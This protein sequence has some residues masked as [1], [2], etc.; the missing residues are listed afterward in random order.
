MKFPNMTTIRQKFPREGLVDVRK[1]VRRVIA[2]ASIAE[3]IGPGQRVGITVGSR[4]ISNIVPIL[5]EVVE[6]VRRAGAIPVLLAAMGSHGGGTEEGQRA[7][8][9]GLGITGESVGAPV[10][11]SADSVPVGKLQDGMT[12]LVSKVAL[13]CDAIIVVNRVKPHTSFH[14]PTE[15]GLHKMLAI[16]LGGPEGAAALH[17][18]G[19]LELPRLI[20]AAAR[21]IMKRL[22]IILGL[23][24][25][26]D[27]YDD[28]KQ[29]VAVPPH[30]FLETEKKL[31]EEAKKTLPTLPVD[32]LD[33]LIIESMGKIYSGTGM[34]TNVIGRLRITGLPE[35]DKPYIKRIVILDLAS[36]SEGNGNGMGLADFTTRKFLNK[37]NFKTTYKNVF[38]STF[39][40]RAMVPVTLE[41]DKQTIAAAL[42]SLG[43]I[44]TTAARVAR[45]HNTLHLEELQVSEALLP[46]LEGNP[47]IEVISSAEEMAFDSEENLLPMTWDKQ[48]TDI[49]SAKK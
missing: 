26:E 22:P 10:M 33:M 38:T 44:D 24:I 27:A 37:V 47:G 35:P 32:A 5:Q 30:G 2:D 46:E 41:T 29:I 1:T 8:L 7:V 9:S 11:T 31:L 25:L 20:P 42:R 43:D 39:V 16:G 28:T 3:K 4:G 14:G 12:V 21:V 18:K 6:A 34:D 36:G 13:T 23:A 48:E 45:I 17:S 49:K 40:Q 15:S 19:A